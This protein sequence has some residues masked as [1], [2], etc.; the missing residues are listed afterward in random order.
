MIGSSWLSVGSCSP[1]AHSLLGESS[2]S[3]QWGPRLNLSFPP[4]P[5]LL[6]PC[7]QRQQ[8]SRLKC[9]GIL[10]CS[11]SADVFSHQVLST[12]PSNGHGFPY[13]TVL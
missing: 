8:T 1:P 12:F 9:P 6:N 4:K 11:L 3:P 13:P 2:E 7:F 5:A 10:I